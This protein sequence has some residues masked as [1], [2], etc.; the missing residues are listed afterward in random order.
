MSSLESVQL[1]ASSQQTVG[2]INLLVT[3]ADGS[4]PVV[5]FQ[6]FVYPGSNIT[7]SASIYN[8]TVNVGSDEVSKPADNLYSVFI[9]TELTVD[10][11]D[12]Y[13]VI[14]AL[15]SGGTTSAYSSAVLLPL[16]PQAISLTSAALVRDAENYSTTATVRAFFTEGP[17]PV[18]GTITYN[19]GVQYIT[20]DGNTKFTVLTG[21][22]YGDVLSG[23]VV[24]EITDSEGI[25]DAW[26]A[27]QVV[28]TLTE[29]ETATSTLSNTER[30]IDSDTPLPPGTLSGTYEYS[31]GQVVNLSWI[32]SNYEAIGEAASYKVYKNNELLTTVSVERTPPAA[33]TL[34]DTSFDGLLGTD[35]SYYVTT[36]GIEE[37]KDESAP[38]NT[39]TFHIVQPSSAPTNVQVMGVSSTNSNGTQDI[40]VTFQNPENVYDDDSTGINAYFQITARDSTGLVLGATDTDTVKYSS[41]ATSYTVNFNDLTFTPDVGAN[42]QDIQV[43]VQLITSENGEQLNG[44]TATKTATIGPKPL[45]Y[46]VD[47]FSAPS[48]TTDANVSAYRVISASALHTNSITY[49]DTSNDDHVQIADAGTTPPDNTISTSNPFA[50]C[51]QYDVT[52]SSTGAGTNTV[53]KLSAA[54]AYGTSDVTIGGAI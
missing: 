54:N 11:S 48:W 2:G 20:D 4:D 23:A 17:A 21:L 26:V 52:V 40:T 25:D 47:N 34:E 49:S 16:A 31:N 32:P 45:I 39:V 53:L 30:A 10:N 35:V 44:N 38:S 28:R 36:A 22:T 46:Q 19:L 37:N 12:R 27:V 51:Y 29:G 33:Y 42:T 7:D 43:Q 1:L 24:G 14:R 13:V 15:F 6:Y 8:R 41:S 18:S 3:T 5:S 50:G 9:D